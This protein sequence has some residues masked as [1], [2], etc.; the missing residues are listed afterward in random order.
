MT[1]DLPSAPA[2]DR[3]RDP[4]LAVLRDAFANARRV[5]ELGSGT[6]QH[7]AYFAPR[8]PGLRWQPTDLPERL[9]GI[10]AWRQEAGAENIESPI[11]L[12]LLDGPWPRVKADGAFS[13]NTAHIVS[14]AGVEAMFQGLAEILPARAPFCLYGPFHY[15]GR[16]TAESN[17]RFDEMLRARDPASGIRDMDDLLVLAANTGFRLDADHDLPANN[18]LLVWARL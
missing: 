5:L 7:A 11:A 4:I 15:H 12:D 3:N 6:G 2:C 10:E 1:D 14:W 13:A 17:A 8:L 16:P 9:P 18:R